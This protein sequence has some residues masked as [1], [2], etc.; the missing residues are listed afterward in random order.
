MHTPRTGNQCLNSSLRTPK[1]REG[2]YLQRHH[3]PS[4]HYRSLD[5]QVW[6]NV[7]EEE[8]WSGYATE[9]L[10]SPGLNLITEMCQ[11]VI[12]STQSLFRYRKEK[13][14][15]WWLKAIKNSF[16]ASHLYSIKA[17]SSG[18]LGWQVCLALWSHE[19]LKGA[20]LIQVGIRSSLPRTQN[21]EELTPINVGCNWINVYTLRQGF[22]KG[23]IELS[24]VYLNIFLML[25]SPYTPR[26]AYSIFNC[27]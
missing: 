18:Y 2:G 16:R 26:P 14:G 25:F 19:S 1:D 23:T 8:V 17:P 7:G 11:K 13:M 6:P 3:P 10:T 9:A 20:W 24:C 4:S 12:I 15:T 22:V 21:L 5:L 27:W